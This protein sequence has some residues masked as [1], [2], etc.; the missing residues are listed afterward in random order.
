MR[1]LNNPVIYKN[2]SGKT[3]EDI[4]VGEVIKVNMLA[5]KIIRKEKKKK[6]FLIQLNLYIFLLFYFLKLNL[7]I[8]RKIN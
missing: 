5:K 1:S 6:V 4:E 8:Q 3:L 2:A 7:Y